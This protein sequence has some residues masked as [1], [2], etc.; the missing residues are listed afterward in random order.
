MY[1][2]RGDYGKIPQTMKDKGVGICGENL[3]SK[4][5]TS[6][7]TTPPG[8]FPPTSY[9]EL[10]VSNRLFQGTWLEYG[11]VLPSNPLK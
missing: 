10:E 7:F 11:T 8:D 9:P 3:K 1:V 2:E 6:L 4:T 5:F